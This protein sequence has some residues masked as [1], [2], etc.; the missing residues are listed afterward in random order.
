M[1]P[2]LCALAMGARARLRLMLTPAG[3]KIVRTAQTAKS[4]QNRRKTACRHLILFVDEY[5]EF[6]R[7]GKAEGG[8]GTFIQQV[9]VEALGPQQRHITRTKTGKA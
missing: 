5:G 7:M 3:Y 6:V 9:G 1:Y 4:F 2:G 8:A